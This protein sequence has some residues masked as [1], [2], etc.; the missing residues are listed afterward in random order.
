VLS[1]DPARTSPEEAVAW[2]SRY[3]LLASAALSLRLP[4]VDGR[5]QSDDA[6]SVQLKRLTDFSPVFAARVRRVHEGLVELG[7]VPTLPR[8]RAGGPLP[9]YISYVDP[10]TGSNL[11]NLNSQ[12][13]YVM[14]RELRDELNGKP[15]V[16]ADTR[17]ANVSLVDDGAAAFVLRIARQQKAR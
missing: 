8:P 2:L 13:F 6:V 1:V 16:G 15:Y 5:E 12:K 11:G 7:Y 9:S 10:V 14:R 3:E 4:N 17:Y